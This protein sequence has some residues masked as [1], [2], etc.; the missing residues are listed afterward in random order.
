MI[1]PIQPTPT[2]QPKPAPTIQPIQPTPTV[3]PKPAPMV[4]PVQS[5]PAAQP[6]PTPR[7]QKR[8]RPDELQVQQVVPM[9][10]TQ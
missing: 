2:V 5:V 7:E 9:S 1:E 6:K 3:Q 10:G 4:Q 8:D